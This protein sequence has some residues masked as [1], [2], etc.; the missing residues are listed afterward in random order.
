[1]TT[2]TTS[3]SDLAVKASHLGVDLTNDG[4]IEAGLA[5]HWRA[6][7][8]DPGNWG[9]K[10]LLAGALVNEGKIDEALPLLSQC[11]E[12]QAFIE[13][14]KAYIHLENGEVEK[15]LPLFK[16]AMAKDPRGGAA[17]FDYAFH[18]LYAGHWEEGLKH[19]E[20]RR[21]YRVERTFNN[22]PTWDG[23]RIKNLLVWCEQ[24]VGDCIQF[25]RY[26]PWVKTQVD[27]VIFG[28]PNNLLALFDN[29]KKW[30][31]IVPL[32][33][34]HN[35]KEPE[36]EVALLS[37]PYFHGTN[38]NNIPK[39]PNVW[40]IGT[41]VGSLRNGNKIR[42]GVVWS[43]NPNQIRNKFRSIPFN[44]IVEVL[45]A[46]PNFELYSLQCGAAAADIGKNGSQSLITDLSGIVYGDWSASGAVMRELDVF[47]APCTGPVHLAAALGV[48]TYLCLNLTP[49]WRWFTEREDSV[50]YNSMKLVR[51]KKRGDWKDVLRRVADDIN[52]TFS[53]QQIAA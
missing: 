24:G 27:N 49:D 44:D 39:D 17:E 7:R 42:V 16:S 26:I 6:V 43:G 15:S 53:E 22:L 20:C 41:A 46:H 25:A 1:M 36:A 29:Y 12:D 50:W 8:L 3:N 45:G 14:I 28:V 31:K 11:K 5:Q 35:E 32:T 51:Q 48:K 18:T 30:A 40:N 37:L 4:H 10:A 23:K 21:Q 9:F 47:V 38:F 52:K 33:E 19:Y 2:I 34:M 13:T